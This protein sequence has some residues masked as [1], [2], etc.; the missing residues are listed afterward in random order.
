ME[1]IEIRKGIFIG[2]HKKGEDLKDT[3]RN[4]QNGTL[5]VDLF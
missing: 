4:T 3:Q 1:I 5:N 2:L